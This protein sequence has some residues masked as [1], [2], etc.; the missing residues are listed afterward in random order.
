MEECGCFEVCSRSWVAFSV[1]LL[2]ELGGLCEIGLL[3]WMGVEVVCEVEGME[4]KKSD[5]GDLCGTRLSGGRG[6]FGGTTLAP[7]PE[8]Y[9]PRHFLT[10]LSYAALLFPWRGAWLCGHDV[11]Q[12]PF[13]FQR[14]QAGFP[15]IAGRSSRFLPANIWR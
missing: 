2:G 7:H 13:T 8:T 12:T 4:V 1:R 11:K 5:V 6:V 10:N 9:S 3:C 15:S 14:V